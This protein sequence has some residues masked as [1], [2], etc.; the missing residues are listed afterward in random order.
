MVTRKRKRSHTHNSF[1]CVGLG[2]CCSIDTCFIHIQEE[3]DVK[4]V[5]KSRR[6]NVVTYYSIDA[7]QRM[8]ETAGTT[9][10]A[11]HTIGYCNS[12]S[13]GCSTTA[14]ARA[15]RRSILAVTS[16]FNS[17]RVSRFSGQGCEE[18]PRRKKDCFENLSHTNKSRTTRGRGKFDDPMFNHSVESWLAP[19]AVVNLN[20]LR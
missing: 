14:V 2:R 12:L 8:R 16:A 7:R 4:P 9:Q 3:K 5:P 20:R 18:Y 19:H 1:A 17:V 6:A 10:R 15:I 13:M 11:N